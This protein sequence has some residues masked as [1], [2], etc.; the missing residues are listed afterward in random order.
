VYAGYELG[1]SI[2]EKVTRRNVEQ[3]VRIMASLSAFVAGCISV[4]FWL[5]LGEVQISAL[6]IFILSGIGI[7]LV[8]HFRGSI[9]LGIGMLLGLTLIWGVLFK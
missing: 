2:A 3:P 7:Y 8:L 9:P 6:S 4:L 1:F 5:E